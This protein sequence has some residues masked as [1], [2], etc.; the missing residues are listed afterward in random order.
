MSLT[1]QR[2]ENVFT[3]EMDDTLLMLSLEQGRYFSL[4]G[5]G[6]RI[7]ALLAEPTTADDIVT[8]LSVEFDVARAICQTE[9]EAFLAALRE[10]RLLV[11][12]D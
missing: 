9:V 10:H 4:E 7:W 6:P 8:T 12:A 2:R 3:S 1:I 11:E 5:V